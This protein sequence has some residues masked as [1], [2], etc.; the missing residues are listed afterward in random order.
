MIKALKIVTLTFAGL[1]LSINIAS[2]SSMSTERMNPCLF[3][4]HNLQNHGYSENRSYTSEEIHNLLNRSDIVA[5]NVDTLVPGQSYQLV[6]S[7]YVDHQL[8]R[9]TLQALPV[10]SPAGVVTNITWEKSTL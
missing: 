2:A 1:L 6:Y 9:A 7:C 4:L 8:A 3:S 10:N 5:K